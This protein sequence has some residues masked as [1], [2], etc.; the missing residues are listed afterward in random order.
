MSVNKVILL[1][2]LGQDPDVKTVGQNVV[3]T[4]SVATDESWTDKN[5]QRTEKTEWH[6]VVVWGRSAENCGKYLRKGRQ[7]Y[8]EGR[9]ETR[10]W[11][12][13]TGAERATTEIRGDRV[14]F[15]GGA[16]EQQRAPQDEPSPFAPAPTPAPNA[17][18]RRDAPTMDDDL[19][20]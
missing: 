13:K 8:V 6:R 3:A 4:F 12:D 19:P 18:P 10:K 15:I 7:V 11:Q 17:G 16:Q 1:G 2:R 14:E 9:L 5:G 20:F